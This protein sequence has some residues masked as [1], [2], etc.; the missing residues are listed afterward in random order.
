MHHSSSIMLSL[1][2]L[3]SSPF[4]GFLNMSRCS[5]MRRRKLYSIDFFSQN[6]VA[7]HLHWCL[8]TSSLSM[9]PAF[10]NAV[11]TLY[12]IGMWCLSLLVSPM[13]IAQ[14]LSGLR[15]ICWASLSLS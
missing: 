15:R 6:G 2:S 11:R 4:A 3:G 12:A 1:K 9:K 5:C 8:M 7:L 13:R 14:Y 10:R